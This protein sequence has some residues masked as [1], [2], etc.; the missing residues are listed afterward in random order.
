M[1]GGA[2]KAGATKAGATKAG[3]TKAGAAKGDRG[4]VIGVIVTVNSDHGSLISTL[5]GQRF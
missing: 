3:A 4:K 1:T 2:A 5:C